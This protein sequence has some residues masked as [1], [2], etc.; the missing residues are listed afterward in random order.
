LRQRASNGCRELPKPIGF[1]ITPL[2]E[3]VRPLASGAAYHFAQTSPS[4]TT[5]T[6][7]KGL[8]ERRSIQWGREGTVRQG[9]DVVYYAFFYEKC[10]NV[11]GF[12]ASA[13]VA[14]IRPST[15][16]LPVCRC[17]PLL[18]SCAVRTN[19]D[20]YVFRR[21]H[22]EGCARSNRQLTPFTQLSKDAGERALQNGRIVLHAHGRL[23]TIKPLLGRAIRGREDGH[24]AACRPL[25]HRSTP[26]PSTAPTISRMI[27]PFSNLLKHSPNKRRRNGV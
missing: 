20:L 17:A 3:P 2:I 24:D 22:S 7:R 5:S 26:R 25:N 15:A 19:D 16:L 18:F 21:M 8:D 4:A 23:F 13:P 1:K 10:L 27:F 12:A 6:W 9:L 14:R 11:L